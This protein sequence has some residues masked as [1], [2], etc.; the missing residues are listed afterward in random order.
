MSGLSFTRHPDTS[1]LSYSDADWARCPETNR[2]TYGYSIFIGGNLI[3]WS[4]KKQSTVARSNCESNYRAMTNTSIELDWV[5]NL[6]RELQVLPSPH[7]TLLCDNQSDIFLSQNTIAHKRAKHI[8]LNYHFVRELV[9][10]GRLITQFVPSHLQLVDVF[11]KSL[12]RPSF[13]FLRSKLCL[14]LHPRS[15]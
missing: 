6:L 3:F 11:T 2:S 5:T 13:E 15:A 14:C 12:S 8:D 7:P 10:S 1:I 9:S 4:A